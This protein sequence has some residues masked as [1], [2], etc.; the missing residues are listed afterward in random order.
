MPERLLALRDGRREGLV[1]G[2][3][4]VC[5]A[6][7]L[8]LRAAL[9]E[10]RATGAPLLVE[11]TCNQVNQFGGYT[12]MTPR[13]FLAFV[14]DLAR[15]AGLPERNLILGGDHLGPNPWKNEPAEAALARLRARR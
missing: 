9:E 7:P 8:V 4:S 2:I 6:H 13:D 1:R 12:G 10:A 5:S 11:A 15:E 3:P 14:G